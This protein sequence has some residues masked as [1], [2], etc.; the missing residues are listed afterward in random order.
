MRFIPCM[1]IG[2]IALALERKHSPTKQR[3]ELYHHVNTLTDTI[4]LSHSLTHKPTHT[5]TH[6][7]LMCIANTSHTQLLRHRR[8]FNT[9][10]ADGLWAICIHWV[11]MSK[12]TVRANLKK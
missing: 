7:Y 9:S 12:H 1:Y 3:F 11:L 4:T 6:A 10:G 2:I 5:H 8:L